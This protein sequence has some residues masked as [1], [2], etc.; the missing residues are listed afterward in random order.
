MTQKLLI[1][2]RDTKKELREAIIKNIL[3]EKNMRLVSFSVLEQE[4]KLG[5]GEMLP[6]PKYYEAWCIVAMP[7]K[8]DK[9]YD[10]LMGM[11][12]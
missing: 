8:N 2:E 9:F 12:E 10:D 11:T 4:Q 5:Y 6:A 7:D 3:E 1:I